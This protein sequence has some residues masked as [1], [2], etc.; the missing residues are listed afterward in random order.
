MQ[1]SHEDW[2]EAQTVLGHLQKEHKRQLEETEEQLKYSELDRQGSLPPLAPGR[3]ARTVCVT[4]SRLPHDIVTCNNALTWFS[5]VMPKAS[6]SQ[7][8]S[9]S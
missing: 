1:A 8:S 9:S 6:A 4:V 7:S 5:A 2:C 3:T